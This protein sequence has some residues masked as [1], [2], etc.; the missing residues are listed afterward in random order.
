[1][2]SA[3]SRREELGVRQILGAACGQLVGH[4]MPPAQ[5]RLGSYEIT[6]KL[7]EGGMGEVYRATDF[8]LHCLDVTS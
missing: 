1:M 3:V 7:G 4:E 2:D 6:A 5:N 8:R